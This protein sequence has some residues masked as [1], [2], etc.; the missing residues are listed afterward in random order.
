MQR[1]S[2]LGVRGRC[3]TAPA[4]VQV[5]NVFFLS[6]QGGMGVQHVAEAL[7]TCVQQPEDGNVS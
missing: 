3:T 5:T 7:I 1:A 4:V 6:C 2:V